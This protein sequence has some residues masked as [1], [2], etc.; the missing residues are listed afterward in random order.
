MGRLRVATYNVHDCVGRDGEYAPERIAAVVAGLDADVIALQEVTL[1]HAGDVITLLERTTAMRAVDG[2]LFERGV[3][4]YG[5]VLLTRQPVA[6][7]RVHDLTHRD[8]E[9][10]GIVDAQLVVDGQCWRVLATHLG[11]SWRERRQQLQTAAG[12]VQDGDAATV[13]LG[14]FNIW[15]GARAFAPLTRLG[16]VRCQPASF[17]TW[18]TPLLSLDR[19]L[20]RRPAS[21]RRCTRIMSPVARIASDHFPVVAEVMHPPDRT[22]R[23]TA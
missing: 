21:L 13:I 11:L 20:V 12:I 10:R 5:N 8:R 3:G 2:T 7:Q 22:A 14:D 1:D 17:P 18:F 16:F 6:E 23:G 9:P 4:R 15:L 19:I